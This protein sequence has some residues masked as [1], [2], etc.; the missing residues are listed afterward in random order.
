[1]NTVI[2]ANDVRHDRAAEVRT[3]LEQLDLILKYL[4]AAIDV[5]TPEPRELKRI[6]VW[7]QENYAA[8]VRGEISVEQWIEGTSLPSHVEPPDYISA[9]ESITFFTE[10]FYFFAWRLM[11]ALNIKDRDNL[12]RFPKLNPIKAQS[13]R[14]VR[15]ELLQHP[16][17]YSQN[18]KQHLTLTGHGPILRTAE[19]AI[20]SATGEVIPTVNSVD[21]GLYVTAKEFRGELQEAFDRAIESLT[22]G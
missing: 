5:V 21:K 11:E 10:S 4:L 12:L 9:W 7:A 16:E 22:S 8:H 14:R 15:N 17:R 18:F 13:V 20:K 2:S 6:H 1:M 19:V 3:R